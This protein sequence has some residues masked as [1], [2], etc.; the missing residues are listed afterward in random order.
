MT[1]Q[2]IALS[3]AAISLL[4]AACT[5]VVVHESDGKVRVENGIGIVQLTTYPGRQP[6]VIQSQGLGLTVRD[7]AVTLGYFSADMAVLPIDDCRI[8]IWFDEDASPQSI[9]AMIGEADG[10]CTLGPGAEHKGQQQQEGG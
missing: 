1:P 6:Q 8:V 2:H 4:A 10:I 5:Q 7:G 3:T 9:S